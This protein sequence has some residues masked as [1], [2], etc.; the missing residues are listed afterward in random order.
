MKPNYLDFVDIEFK[1][2]VAIPVDNYAGFPELA[3]PMQS[4][5]QNSDD[6]EKLFAPDEQQ[7]Q[8]LNRS[9]MA[10]T[11]TAPQ[12]NKP[13]PQSVEEFFGEC[14][15]RSSDPHKI[16]LTK[17]LVDGEILVEGWNSVGECVY[18]RT[19]SAG[20]AIDEGSPLAKASISD[21]MLRTLAGLRSLLLPEEFA[22]A[23]KAVKAFDVD[24]F[25]QI[26]R[27]AQAAA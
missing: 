2:V 15:K 3:H 12:E 5:Q 22:A 23:E 18:S 21:S 7:L 16:K 14:E 6:L 1:D 9:R 20:E 4:F 27:R 24:L 17:R 10:P 26:C 25:L 19:D 13:E 11:R 8:K